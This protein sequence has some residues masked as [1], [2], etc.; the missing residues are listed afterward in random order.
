MRR[1]HLFEIGDQAWCP[2][3][4]RDAETD[5]LEF[6][7][8]VGNYYA[9]IVPALRTA[10]EKTRQREIVDL[11]AGGGGP[12]LR[13]VSYFSGEPPIRVLLTDKFPNALSTERLAGAAHGRI[14]SV[15]ESVDA[16]AVPGTLH[17]FRTMFTAFHHFRPVQCRAILADAVNNRVGI[18]VFEFTERS[19][20][21]VLAVAF[22]P[23][24]VLIAVPFLRPIRWQTFLLTYLLPVIPLGALFDGIVSCFRTYSPDEL[25]A[26]VEPFR[27][28]GYVWNIGQVRSWRSPVPITYLVGYPA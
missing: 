25:A 3:A 15:R 19:L 24:A 11:C 2:R 9:P 16:M 13:L 10:L 14:E 7:L 12:W 23:L 5:L 1:L 22:T 20:V 17:G 6:F 18:G 27:A 21:G 28:S 8:R 26:L 4:F